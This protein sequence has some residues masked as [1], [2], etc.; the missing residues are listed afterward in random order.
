MRQNIFLIFITL[1]TS[2]S[3]YI[4]FNIYSFLIYPSLNHSLSLLKRLRWKNISL[5]LP[6]S[7]PLPFI[8]SFYTLHII[9][10]CQT[11]VKLY[12]FANEKKKKTCFLIIII[13]ISIIRY[14]NLHYKYLMP[15]Y[16]NFCKCE[17][18]SYT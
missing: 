7:S 10:I 8:H 4:M 13:T 11:Q 3:L 17:R 1:N 2:H 15:V 6:C 16:A 18:V 12:H 14:Y 9:H 5:F